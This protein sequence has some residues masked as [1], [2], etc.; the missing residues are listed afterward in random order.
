M[1]EVLFLKLKIIRVSEFDFV[2]K[3][4]FDS[5]HKKG[6]QLDIRSCI[7]DLNRL[8]ANSTRNNDWEGGDWLTNTCDS[9]FDPKGWDL[10]YFKKSCHMFVCTRGIKCTCVIQS[11]F[12]PVLLNPFKWLRCFNTSY[13]LSALNY[14]YVNLFL[15]LFIYFCLL[16]FKNAKAKNR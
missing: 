16:C 8:W 7:L 4:S 10:F 11:D 9:D 6:G 13:C 1:Y 12:R 5:Y 15:L 3:S 14:F 2:V